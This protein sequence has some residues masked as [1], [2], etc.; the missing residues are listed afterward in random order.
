MLEVNI[1][2]IIVL[3]MNVDYWDISINDFFEYINCF[4]IGYF[5]FNILLENNIFVMNRMFLI[6]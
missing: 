6:I 2:I 4:R 5:V 1:F 3:L